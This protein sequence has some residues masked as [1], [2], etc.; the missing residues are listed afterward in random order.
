M[1][2]DNAMTHKEMLQ[3]LLDAMLEQQRQLCELSRNDLMV[4]ESLRSEISPE[5]VHAA[6]SAVRSTLYS[7]DELSDKLRVLSSQVR[8]L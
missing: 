3:H 4:I 7:V 6:A 8:S 5:A 1:P 2:V